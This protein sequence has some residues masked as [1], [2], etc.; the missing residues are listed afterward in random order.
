M[1][2]LT[3]PSKG[4]KVVQVLALRQTVDPIDNYSREFRGSYSDEAM[5]LMWAH[6]YPLILKQKSCQLPNGPS[7]ATQVSGFALFS[8]ARR[9]EAEIP[10]SGAHPS[11]LPDP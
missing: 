3:S 10:P 8:L 6:Q 1:F 9:S 2:R 5:V 7:Y 11:N 4:I